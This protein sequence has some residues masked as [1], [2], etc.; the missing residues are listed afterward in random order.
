MSHRVNISTCEWQDDK[1]LLYKDEET[2]IF[3]SF[4]MNGYKNTQNRD[5]VV[6][7][8][9]LMSWQTFILPFVYFL[10]IQSW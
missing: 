1:Y 2:S 10:I 4:T 8:K 6:C 7:S 3:F 9:D 5:D